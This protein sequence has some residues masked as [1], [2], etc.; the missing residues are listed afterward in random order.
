MNPVKKI[1]RWQIPILSVVAIKK[2]AGAKA[3]LTVLFLFLKKVI[4]SLFKW[5]WTNFRE[6]LRPGYDVLLSTGDRVF[7]TEHEKNQY[8]EALEQH[9]LVMEVYGMCKSLGL[10]V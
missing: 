5:D 2:R 7:F 8:N 3:W 6:D 10:R 4:I 9:A 1:G